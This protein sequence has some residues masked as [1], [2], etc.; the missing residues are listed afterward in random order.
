MEETIKIKIET[1]VGDIIIELYPKSAPITVENF[2]NYVNDGFYN[3]TVF[4]RII[5]NFM[6]Q[7]GGFLENGTEKKTNAPIKLE[8]NNGLKNEK[9]TIAM[10]RT[11]VPDSATSQFFINLQNNEFLNYG[12]RDEGYA[13]FGKVIE[14]MDIVETIG[15]ANT[16]EKHDMDD[17]PS[18][19]IIIKSIIKI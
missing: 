5:K 13:V 10:A 8:S 17:W 9:G 7:G 11:I 15:M 2:L 1:N 4:H 19:E 16:E 6:I 3:K 12:Y 14:G 18:E